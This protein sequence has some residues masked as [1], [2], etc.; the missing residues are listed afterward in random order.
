MAIDIS[1]IESVRLNSASEEKVIALSLLDCTTANFSYGSAIWLYQPPKLPESDNFNLG[2]HLRESLALTLEAYP[3]WLGHL[4]V[5]SK[6]DG[7]G[8]PEAQHL[9]PHAR[10]FGRIYA[11]FGTATDPGVEFVYARSSA[12]LDSIYPM[13]R[14]SKQPL[15][16]CETATFHSFLAATT[17]AHAL[18]PNI[19]DE[20][21]RLSPLMAVQVTELACGGF[22]VAK[23]AIPALT[24]L[25][26]PALLDS[27]AA[28]D[29]NA[30]EPDE[31]ILQK[32]RSLPMHRYDWWASAATCPW[33]FKIP[34]PFDTEEQTSVGKLMPWAEWDLASP[35][36]NYVVHLNRNQVD[37]LWNKANENASEKL[38]RHDAVLGHIW[39][40]IAR[41]R[42]L[43]DDDGPVHCDLVYGVRP[44]FQLGSEFQGSP[45]MM[46]NV[47]L[48]VS[49]VADESNLSAIATQVR[50]TLRVITNKDNMAAHL[51]SIAY[52]KSP[53]RIWQ[54]FLGRRHILV[55]TWGR[56]GIYDIDFGLGSE[57]SFAEGVVPE[58]DG[59]ILI[60]EAPGKP[61]AYWTDNGVD[62]SIHIRTEDMERLIKDPSLLPEASIGDHDLDAT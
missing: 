56:A 33:P 58:M 39:S 62:I 35:V 21:G 1:V 32:A 9:P 3:Q 26:D 17:L 30:E 25:F 18:Q 34:A 47:E 55:T 40:C 23:S 61:G 44:S 57:C 38:S 5:V 60:K 16:S 37:V 22:V 52:E 2:Y 12:T 4:K 59:N 20:A 53:Q 19:A 13:D 8:P 27:Q 46:M 41:A 29:I 51:Y 7:V 24:P 15:W 54:A 10:R 48:A 28:G 43:Q 14:P 6:I 36:S 42:G 45:C 11:H 31:D 49:K 50:Q